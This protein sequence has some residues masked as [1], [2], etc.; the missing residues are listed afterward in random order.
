MGTN[1][2]LFL[3]FIENKP[4]AGQS[5]AF[6]ST[7]YQVEH[8]FH[9]VRL[10]LWVVG[11]TA[12]NSR[13]PCSTARGDK[14][15]RQR[16]CC[17]RSAHFPLSEQAASVKLW[18]HSTCGRHKGTGLH[19][20][21]KQAGT[22]PEPNQDCLRAS[23][24]CDVKS[25]P[26]GCD[27]AMDRGT[28][29]P[30][31]AHTLVSCLWDEEDILHNE[32]VEGIVLVQGLLLP[33]KESASFKDSIV[34]IADRNFLTERDPI[35]RCGREG[36]CTR[37]DWQC[38][39]LSV[40]LDHHTLR[41][42]RAA[43]PSWLIH[44][45]LGSPVRNRIPTD[46]MLREHL[47]AA[48]ASGM[49]RLRGAIASGGAD[50]DS[51]AADAAP[52]AGLPGAELYL[53]QE[54]PG[55]GHRDAPEPPAPATPP[56]P[57]VGP[58]PPRAAGCRSPWS[59]CRE[60]RGAGAPGPG[61]VSRGVQE[62]LVPVPGL[63]G[64]RSPWSR[65]REPRGAGAP[66]PGAVS[67][68]VQ[69]PLV[70][71][72]FAL[73][74][75]EVVAPSL[76]HGSPGL[77]HGQDPGRNGS[78]RET[79]KALLR[80]SLAMPSPA[81]EPC[82]VNIFHTEAPTTNPTTQRWP[83][84]SPQPQPPA[85]SAPRETWAGQHEFLLSCLGY[86]VGLG[87]VWRFPYLC[88]RNGGGAFLIPY[89]IM[90]LGTGLPLFL[91]ELSLGQYGAAGPI[92]VWKCC[93]LL[94]G[95][96]VSMLIVSSL[97]SLYYNV[98]IA[99]A[100]YYLGSSFQSPLPWSCHAP[101]NMGLCQNTSG[102]S[103][104]SEVFWNERVLGATHSSG[105]GDPGAVRWPLALCLL[106]AWSLVFLCMLRGIR[107]SGKV[108][109]FTATFPYLVILI[110]IIRGAT[111]DGSLDGVRFYLSPD[112]S[113]LQSAQV[114]SDAA[115]QIF[116]S[117]GIGF[118]GLLSMASYNRFN[119]NVIRDTVVIAI[120]NCCTSFLAGFA[121]F[122]VLGHMAWRK[123]VPV[124]SVVDSGPGLAFVAYPE[125]LSLLPGSP[126][127]SSLFFLMLLMLGVDTQFGNIEGITTAIVDEFPALRDWK[128]K[129]ALLG[130]L[131][132][133]FY[134]LG[135]LLVTQGGIFWF[136]LIDTYSTGF[137]LII[138]ALF[139]CLG[140]AFCYGVNR[141]CRDIVDMICLCPPWCSHVLGYF[142]VCWAFLT[143]C[144][145]LFTLLY[146]FLDMHNVPL[147]YGAYEYPDWGTGL[148]ICMGVLTCLQIPLWALVA[149]ARESGTLSDRFQKAR[150]P[151]RSWRTATARDAAADVIDVPFTI[152]LTS[153]DFTAAPH[154]SSGC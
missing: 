81:E 43:P 112:W 41:R 9:W 21:R 27:P 101:E 114:W 149:L 141:F 108:V 63:A 62:P 99:W 24:A 2:G 11:S 68:G 53:L 96:G 152:A 123:R 107:S 93:P 56:E 13:G 117:L 103:S 16:G 145:L 127:W 98:I 84:L 57:T 36:S 83:G 82:G 29:L 12:A 39:V 3:Y 64:C 78:W 124:G 14:P 72:R 22:A 76:D 75:C 26:K 130:S 61:A 32:G 88:Y 154:G 25:K 139:M 125:A 142:R 59:R 115:S 1:L 153:S 45:C 37:L 23:D 17:C 120:G 69:E 105:L 74:Q 71:H 150:Q 6:G 132:T 122:S 140:I 18:E 42:H 129:T 136:T 10:W 134:L 67:R 106:A 116:Y 55:T 38:G 147:R 20:A 89:F 7:Q 85:P 33:S 54:M 138:V 102:S 91:M 60:P 126:L 70:P 51:T 100:V 151:L 30:P 40:N 119:N 8:L 19:P 46:L 111:L 47:L 35:S 118:G 121:I 92:S 44:G 4:P 5:V 34:S 66:G 79:F 110:L 73:V 131:C 133:A 95:I 143:P 94:R 113:R 15:G 137:G 87:N 52:Q 48:E 97:V 148:G 86:C 50:G 109:Y 90:L 49:N 28:W 65:C 128:R 80:E 146:T 58:C 104:A 144:L 77:V 135:L 31:L